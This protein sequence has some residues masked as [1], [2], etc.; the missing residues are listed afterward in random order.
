M[1]LGTGVCGGVAIILAAQFGT[2][3]CSERTVGGSSGGIECNDG[4]D[5]NDNGVCDQCERTL[6]A[7]CAAYNCAI[8]EDLECGSSNYT[9][10]GY[11]R[12]CGYLIQNTDGELESF[13]VW[14]EETG[15]LVYS[16]SDSTPGSGKDC[17]T[18]SIGEPP[19][20]SCDSW[21]S[22]CDPVDDGS[23]GS[24]GSG[25]FGGEGGASP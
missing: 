19:Q 3:A 7:H 10:T 16:F 21:E 8:P 4:V 17:D 22:A 6:E 11:S 24:G 1:R 14:S 12:G 2:A 13:T 5:S 9:F 23:G 15:Q 18:Q 25:G 20:L